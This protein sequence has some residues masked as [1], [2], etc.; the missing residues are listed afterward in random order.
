MAP[1][2]LGGKET[3]QRDRGLSGVG[4]T[5]DQVSMKDTIP[6]HSDRMGTKLED[7]AGTGEFGGEGG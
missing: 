1:V 4:A 7:L 2:W 5:E 6:Q 3:N